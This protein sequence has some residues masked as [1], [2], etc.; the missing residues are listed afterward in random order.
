MGGD[1]GGDTDAPDSS[2]PGCPL[3]WALEDVKA[4]PGEGAG[5]EGPFLACLFVF[6]TS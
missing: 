2:G 6:P 5:A 4:I 3:G 1:G